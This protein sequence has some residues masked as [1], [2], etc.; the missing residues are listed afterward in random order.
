M[1]RTLAASQARRLRQHLQRGG[2]I[3]YPTE[4]CYGLGCLPKHAQALKKLV[5]LKKRP[6][7]K[8]M[9]VIGDNLSRLQPLLQPLASADQQNI[10]QLWP[11]PTTLLLPASHKVLPLLRGTACHHLAVRVPDHLGARKL[12]HIANT[13]LVSTSCNRAGKRAC[14][15]EREARRQFGRDVMIIGGR[16]GTRRQPSIIIDWNSGQRLR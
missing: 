5:R 3:A 6:Q 7:H 12:C 2:L 1:N 10:T 13:P 8:G 14:T 15:S 16:I 11:A 4:S 9:I